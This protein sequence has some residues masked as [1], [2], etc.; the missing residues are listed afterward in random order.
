VPADAPAVLGIID[1]APYSIGPTFVEA[2]A[3]QEGEKAV[4]DAFRKPPTSDKQ[5]LNPSS[6]L[7]EEKPKRVRAPKLGPEV[8]DARAYALSGSMEDGT[9]LEAAECV[10]DRAAVD[11]DL[12][13]F[14]ISA[15][16]PPQDQIDASSTRS[17]ESSAPARPDG[18]CRPARTAV[19]RR[20]IE[21]RTIGLKVRCSAN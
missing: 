6:Y 9:P 18:A 21:P 17:Q 16:E 19:G 5:V 1:L 2:I 13:A 14:L 20:G 8:L 15:D 4:D 3:I 10:A 11:P 12:R 7:D